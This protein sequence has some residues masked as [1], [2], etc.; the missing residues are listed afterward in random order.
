MAKIRT[1]SGRSEFE[2]S[3][4]CDSGFH[5]EYTGRPFVSPEFIKEIL[6]EFKGETVAGGFNISGPSGFGKWVQENS[7]L[8]SKHASHIAAVL[9]HEKLASFRIEGN[10]VILTFNK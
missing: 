3:G 4:C 7:N 10:R 2:F 9:V 6:A 1:L 5:L 8:S